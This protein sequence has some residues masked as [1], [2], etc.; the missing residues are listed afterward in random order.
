MEVYGE[1][2]NGCFDTQ[3]MECGFSVDMSKKTVDVSGRAIET[4]SSLETIKKQYVTN[5]E[6]VHCFNWIRELPYMFSL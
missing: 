6:S 1:W 2:T 3:I 4:S 5:C